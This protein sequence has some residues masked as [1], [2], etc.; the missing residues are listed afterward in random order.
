MKINVLLLKY[1]LLNRIIF[2]LVNGWLKQ[3]GT[4]DAPRGRNR[5]TTYDW[6]S[7]Q[8]FLY[9]SVMNNDASH[10]CR[11]YHMLTCNRCIYTNLNRFSFMHILD[12]RI[13]SKFCP[14]HTFFYWYLFENCAYKVLISSTSLFIYKIWKKVRIYNKVCSQ[15]N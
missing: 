9:N 11:G 1:I 8:R 7:I 14:K 4:N 3:L 10:T 13:Y 5:S 12:D 6:R 15:F 2:Q